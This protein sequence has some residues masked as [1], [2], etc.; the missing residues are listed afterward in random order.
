MAEFPLTRFTVMHFQHLMPFFY[1]DTPSQESTQALSV[2]SEARGAP[3]RGCE[4]RFLIAP[5]S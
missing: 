4:T 2:T 5:N 3:S 1:P